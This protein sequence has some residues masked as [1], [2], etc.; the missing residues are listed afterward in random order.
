M[1]SRETLSAASPTR[2][3]PAGILSFSA[4]PLSEVPA[5]IAQFTKK[6]NKAAICFCQTMLAEDYLS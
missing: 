1:S 2:R 6:N 4:G 3:D 5:L